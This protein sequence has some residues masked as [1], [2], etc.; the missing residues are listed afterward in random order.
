VNYRKG[1][2]GDII[3]ISQL[4]EAAK[5]DMDNKGIYQWDNIYPTVDDFQHD[6]VTITFMLLRTRSAL[7]LYML[8]AKNMMKHIQSAHGRMLMKRLVI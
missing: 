5:V 2:M 8:L 7:L 3:A 6:I 4:V 1:T